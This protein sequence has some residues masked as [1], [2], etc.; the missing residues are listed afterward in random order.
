MSLYEAADYLDITEG[1]LAS[2]F[3]KQTGKTFV[4]ALTEHRLAVACTLLRDPRNRI[5]EVAQMCG[6]NDPAYFAKVFRRTVGSSPREFRDR[7]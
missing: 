6:Y 2:L 3:R 4:Q 7:E 1:H 5:S